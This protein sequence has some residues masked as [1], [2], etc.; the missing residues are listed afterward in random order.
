LPKKKQRVEEI[1]VT[2]KKLEALLVKD[3]SVIDPKLSF[4]G[5]QIET[6]S[7]FLDVLAF[8]EE[9]NGLALMELKVKEDDG[10]LFQAIR[11]YDWVK[12]RIELI[13]RSYGKEIDVDVDP[14]VI[15]VAPS[16]SENLR[17][18]ARYIDIDYLSLFEYSV[19]QLSDGYKYVYCK[20]VDYGEPYEPKKIPTIEGKLSYITD[21]NVKSIFLNA[22]STL[23]DNG[24]E[25]QPRRRRIS[26]LHDSKVIGKIRCRRQ[27]FKIAS[28]FRGEW[29]DYYNIYTREDWNSFLKK[30]IKPFI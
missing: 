4:L 28:S 21:E 6:D 12:S 30:E 24:I 27:F 25:V 9:D 23:K 29:S 19:L 13:G 5:R 8:H 2:E 18:V 11:Y 7:G 3:L 26:L 17:K 1:E 16:F 20:D 14:W 22:L 10:Q 15:L